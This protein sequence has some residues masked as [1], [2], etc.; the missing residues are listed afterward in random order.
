MATALS[1]FSTFFL[2]FNKG[3]NNGAGN[4]V[5]PNG[6]KSD[7]LWKEILTK[8]SLSNI[9]ENYAQIVE[10]TDE[11]TGKVK[12]KLVFPRYHQL[13]VVQKL[14]ADSKENGV[15]Q[16]YLI[17]HS[18]GSGKSNSITWLAHQ[19]VSL[20]DAANTQPVF[21]SVIVVTDR[22]VLDKQIRDNIKQFAQ[23]AKEV[24]AIETGFGRWQ[25]NHHYHRTE[26][27]L[28]DG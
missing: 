20:H 4:P 18:A 15:G 14:L 27:S 3:I 11:D 16:R 2:P 6:L 8:H 28:C 21:D 7:Y 26:I 12:R 13:K 25:K 22:K 24:E 23:V 10:E 1:G 5:N 19:L 17:Q 9:I